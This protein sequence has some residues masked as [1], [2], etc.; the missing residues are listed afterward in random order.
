ME[1]PKDP[2]MLLSFVNTYLRDKYKSLDDMCADLGVSADEIEETLA[3]IDY[4]YD[5]SLNSFV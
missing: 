5:S 1:L 4:E 3:S 2:A